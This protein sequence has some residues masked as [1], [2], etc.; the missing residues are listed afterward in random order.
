MESSFTISPLAADGIIRVTGAGM[1]T[2]EGVALHFREL[3][4]LVKVAR[5]RHGLARVL[6]DL[7]D[8][9]VQ[10]QDTAA[11]LGKWT[12][13]VYKPVDRVA[14]IYSATLLAMQ[15]KHRVEIF[16][17]AMFREPEPAVEWLLA[18]AD[19]VLPGPQRV[20]GKG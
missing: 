20:A 6:V 1:W 14:T 5:A 16:Q 11:A 18:A 8:A 12:S 4:G 10:T 13:T 9:P 17:I 19:A 15:I 2:P 7:R 3:D